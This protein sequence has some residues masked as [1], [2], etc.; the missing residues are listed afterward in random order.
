M[1]H[2][3]FIIHSVFYQ[4]HVDVA[5]YSKAHK[6]TVIF[7][8]TSFENNKAYIAKRGKDINLET[9]EAKV[10]GIMGLKRECS[11]LNIDYYEV[12]NNRPL[13]EVA[14]QVWEIIGSVI[15]LG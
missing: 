14:E 12:N 10:K 13:P 5:R 8:E 1:P 4:S 15:R 11:R 2:E 3:D 7:L 9:Y 6:L